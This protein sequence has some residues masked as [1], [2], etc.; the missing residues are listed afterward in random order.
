MNTLRCS[1]RSRVTTA[2]ETTAISSLTTANQFNHFQG[3]VAIFDCTLTT[4]LSPKE[5]LSRPWQSRFWWDM[6]W[7]YFSLSWR[8]CSRSSPR[9]QR[10]H[11]RHPAHRPSWRVGAHQHRPSGK[12]WPRPNGRRYSPYRRA[13]PTRSTKEMPIFRYMIAHLHMAPSPIWGASKGLG[14]LNRHARACGAASVRVK[15][16]WCSVHDI[17]PDCRTDKPCRHWRFPG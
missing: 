13:V 3:T 6:P 2:L 9:T 17:S 11:R 1:T 8:D 7:T 12:Q 14:L 16:R 4:S 15:A 10:L 5:L